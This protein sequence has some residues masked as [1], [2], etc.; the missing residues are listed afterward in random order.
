MNQ[1]HPHMPHAQAK[2]AASA[3]IPNAQ[4]L[5]PLNGRAQRPLFVL[6]AIL[7]F[8][9]TLAV[10]SV[11]ANHRMAANWHADLAGTVT[12]QIKPTGL[13]GSR[14]ENRCPFYGK[15]AA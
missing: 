2:I 4:K 8:L 7:A 12:V 3:A 1:L 9:A 10:L 5:L 13:A 14:P 11:A 15:G 6:L